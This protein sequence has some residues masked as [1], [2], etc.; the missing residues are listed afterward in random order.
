MRTHLWFSMYQNINVKLF[1]Q[2]DYFVNFLLD[3]LNIIFLG[4]PKNIMGR[5]V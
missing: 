3:S 1:L 4:D 2:L 5:L